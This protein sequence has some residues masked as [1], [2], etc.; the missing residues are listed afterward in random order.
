MKNKKYFIIG[1]IICSLM[2]LSYV[3]I[4]FFLTGNFLVLG[5][6]SVLSFL[7]ATLIFILVT[8][9]NIGG[10]AGAA[11]VNTGLNL[12]L[13][14]EGGYQLFVVFIGGILYL[15][16]QLSTLFTPIFNV[17]TSIFNV[18]FGFISWLTGVSLP[19]FGGLGNS[20]THLSQVYPY[21]LNIDG[22]S[23]FATLDVIFGSM[24]ILSLYW[25]VS[26]R[27]H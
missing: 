9:L 12:G 17:V 7:I 2:I 14:N 15:G 23:V 27:G 8:N 16:V 24:F 5:G 1:F 25:M 20:L 4:P 21:S 13:N 22:I 19:V 11:T 26:S 6:V 10:Q 3:M 18:V